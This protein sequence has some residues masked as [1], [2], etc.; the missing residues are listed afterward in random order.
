MSQIRGTKEIHAKTYYNQIVKGQRQ[1]I[2]KVARESNM[3]QTKE[4]P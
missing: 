4:S 2:L 3:L 1:K